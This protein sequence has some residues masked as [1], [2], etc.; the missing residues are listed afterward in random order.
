[1]PGGCSGACGDREYR[2][3]N[4]VVH[5]VFAGPAG[6]EQAC[7][8][9]QADAEKLALAALDSS[10]A[11]QAETLACD[12]DCECFDKP[13]AFTPWRTLRKGVIW[14]GQ[15]LTGI[16][17]PCAWKVTITYDY[18]I[19]ERLGHCYHK[20]PTA[21]PAALWLRPGTAEAARPRRPRGRKPA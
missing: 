1:M 8:G 9:E 15:A 14:S 21:M 13:A 18:E 6:Q 12:G 4:A 17:P 3:A 11:A 19:R 20:P 10:M 16:T 2:A 7:A 5:A